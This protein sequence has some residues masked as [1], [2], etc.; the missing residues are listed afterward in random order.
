VVGAD[1]GGPELARRCAERYFEFRFR[2]D[3][4]TLWLFAISAQPA[5]E[6]TLGL[7]LIAFSRS[8]TIGALVEL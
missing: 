5:P 8:D 3:S 6:E 7:E 4:G 1:R 2:R